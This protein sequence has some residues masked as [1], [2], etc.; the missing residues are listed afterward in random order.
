MRRE[1][2]GTRSQCGKEKVQI[3]P[4][5]KIKCVRGRIKCQWRNKGLRGKQRVKALRRKIK[6]QGRT[7]KEQMVLREENKMHEGENYHV[8]V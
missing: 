3:V 8:K 1:I 7:G 2:K 5:G 6:G 4:R